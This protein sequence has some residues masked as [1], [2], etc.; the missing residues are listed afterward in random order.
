MVRPFTRWTW[1][2]TPLTLLA[3][4][5]RAQGPTIQDDAPTPPAA[6]PSD[7]DGD[8]DGSSSPDGDGT[9]RVGAAFGHGV[10]VTSD[11]DRFEMTLRGRVQIRNTLGLEDGQADND[12]TVRT[13]RLHWE[14]HTF[15]PHLSYGVQLAFGPDELAGDSPSPVLDAYLE[16]DRWSPGILRVGQFFVPL[17]R[18]RMMR[19]WALQFVERQQVVTEL[20]L[21]RD[22]GVVLWSQDVLGTGGHL[23]YHVGLFEGDGRN[24]IGPRPGMLPVARLVV[25]PFGAFDEEQEGDLER[26]RHPRLALGVAGAYSFRADRNRATTGDRFELGTVRYLHGAADLH[27][28]M[29]G[30]SVLAE[31]L[32][33][34][35]SPDVRTGVVDGESI[36]E[37]SRSGWGYLVQLG[38]MLTHQVELTTRWEELRALGT[39]D[40]DLVALVAT[41]GREMGVGCNVYLNGHRLKVQT[42]Y[43]VRF[44]EALS[45]A[46]HE[47]RVAI[48]A[49]F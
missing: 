33:R 20:G 3:V 14:G 32:V 9:A 46:R 37:W 42:D 27:F 36:R 39:T 15:T 5:G 49:S 11:D 8:S 22:V 18:A 12:L 21:D 41:T 35:G 17:D 16:Y 7:E 6:S 2:I 43:L 29:H 30:L 47:I 40:P 31:V 44:G 4:T 24:R 1:L 23:G 10:T 45:R 34:R 25:R 26:L 38:Y 28:K 13:L 19:E 48:D